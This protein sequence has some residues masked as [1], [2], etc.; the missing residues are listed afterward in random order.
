MSENEATIE[1]SGPMAREVASSALQALGVDRDLVYDIGVQITTERNG[2]ETET[3]F[4]SCGSEAGNVAA[5]MLSGLDLESDTPNYISVEVETRSEESQ[6]EERGQSGDADST[7]R[8]ERSVPDDYATED[9]PATTVTRL[10]EDSNPHF[11]LA[12]VAAFES[13][14]PNRDGGIV[15]EMHEEIDNPFDNR[16][17]LSSALSVAFR[18]KGF[19]DRTRESQESGGARMRY[20][21]DEDAWDEIERLGWPD[22]VSSVDGTAERDVD[23]EQAAGDD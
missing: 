11:A 6:D 13:K 19:L 17:N 18:Q 22:E 3:S 10:T 7:E 14:Y 15:T 2:T 5:S 1:V 4:A 23:V 16:D 20:F 12:V 9:S 21:M 8:E